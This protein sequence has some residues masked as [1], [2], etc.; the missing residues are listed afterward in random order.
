[1]NIRHLKDVIAP[2]F[3]SRD[4]SEHL[5]QVER[6][7]RLTEKLLAELGEEVRRW[8]TLGFDLKEMG[9]LIWVSQ[10]L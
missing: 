2:L 3:S 7:H 9:R 10:C 6:L 5:G 1:M 8:K 4:P